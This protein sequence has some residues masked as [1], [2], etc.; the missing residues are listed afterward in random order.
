M[1]STDKGKPSAA[2][3]GVIRRAV[4][5]AYGFGK[6]QLTQHSYF[7]NSTATEKDTA[8]ATTADISRSVPSTPP[9]NCRPDS[10]GGHP[11]PG[12]NDGDGFDR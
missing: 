12:G 8:C 4:A 2:A 6:S 1:D 3:S 11:L 10:G 5:I 7:P 9:P